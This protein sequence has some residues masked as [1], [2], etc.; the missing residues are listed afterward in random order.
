MSHVTL[1]LL[2][3]FSIS[4]AANQLRYDSARDPEDQVLHF[5][6]ARIAEAVAR[7]VPNDW[8]GVEICNEQ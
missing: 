5:H 4:T 7:G 8:E 2:L 3:L 6:Q 1:A